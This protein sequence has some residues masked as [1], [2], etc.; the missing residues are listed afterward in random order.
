MNNIVKRNLSSTAITALDEDLANQML[1]GIEQ[2]QATTAVAG[3]GKDLIKLDKASGTWGIGQADEPMQIG[4]HWWVNLLS[5]CHGFVCWS[6]Y[7]GKRKNE[8]LGEIMA[9]MSSPKPA[10]PNPID[11]FPFTEQRSFEAICLNGEDEGREVQF[12]NGSVGTMK[13]MKKLEDAIKLQ[14]R[15]DR[16]HPC[17]VIEFKSESYKHGDYGRIQNPIFEIV[18]WA[19]LQGN[20]AGEEDDAVEE[21]A[22][23]PP[24]P[25]PAA[26]AAP[27]RVKPS[28]VQAAPAPEPEAAPEPAQTA[29]API[30]GQR[31]RPI[32]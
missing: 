2:S 13:A 1:A 25:A 12:K 26:A 27:K 7:Q 15:K 18:A 16:A 32:G 31:R 10:K 6:D 22:P 23:T 8:R 4:S 3:G 20:I 5:V 17:P 21:A 19:D 9:P 30:R 24:T 11:N 14:L 29:A 28:L